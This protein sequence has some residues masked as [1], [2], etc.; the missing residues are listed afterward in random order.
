M[1]AA[2]LLLL[3]SLPSAG[4]G[5]DLIFLDEARPY[6]LRLHLRRDGRPADADFDRAFDRV[7]RYL[8]ADGDGMLYAAEL[9]RAPDARQFVEMLYGRLIGPAAAPSFA[10]LGV[11]PGRGKVA[12]AQLRAYYLRN[13][14]GVEWGCAR[15]R[16]T[17]SPTPCSRA[18]TRTATAG[19]RARS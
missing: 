11:D 19:C 2:S 18:S 3:A 17:A 14:V 9:G 4:D 7:F 16:Q 13:G 15:T 8:D 12:P 1:Y 6:R 5:R 10:D